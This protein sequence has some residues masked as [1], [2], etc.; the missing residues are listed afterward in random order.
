MI[1]EY[2]A[3]VAALVAF[4]MVLRKIVD[5]NIMHKK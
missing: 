4:K 1:G 3:S 5:D 2:L